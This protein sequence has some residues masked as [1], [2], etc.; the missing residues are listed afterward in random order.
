MENIREKERAR[1]ARKEEQKQRVITLIK[2]YGENYNGDSTKENLIE[3]IRRDDGVAQS[4]IDLFDQHAEE[5]SKTLGPNGGGKIAIFP[6][7]VDVL[8][9]SRH[10][11]V[12]FQIR[13][14]GSYESPNNTIMALV[15]RHYR[16]IAPPNMD[17][18]HFE[19]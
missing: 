18:R 3:D 11:R 8:K 7:T 1:K 9:G 5:L 2:R 12:P 13:E 15:V 14:I 17:S 6:E 10:E 19:K 16:Q 4:I